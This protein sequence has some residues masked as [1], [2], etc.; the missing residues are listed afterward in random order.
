MIKTIFIDFDGVIRHWANH[1]IKSAEMK[2]GLPE[3]TLFK[4]AFDNQFLLPAI[5]G[6]QSH[7]DWVIK[8]E[9]AISRDFD[10][11]AAI[12]LTQ[13]W[14]KA[15]CFVDRGFLDKVRKSI[16]EAK[17]VLVTNATDKLDEDL[18]SHH[19]L[20]SFDLVINSATIGIAKPDPSFFQHALKLMKTEPEYAVFIDDQLKNVREAEKH[21]MHGIH[22]TDKVQ[23]LIN[24]N[25]LSRC[26]FAYH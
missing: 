19:L 5:T 18:S 3:G 11:D 6:K 15:D 17:M 23:T 8:V 25:T 14:L 24:L 1:D 2:S 9:D 10:K 21:G 26:S 4:Y 12:T 20:Y 13:A 7:R 22:H 16:P